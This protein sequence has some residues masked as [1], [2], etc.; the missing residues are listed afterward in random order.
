MALRRLRAQAST[1]HST[2]VRRRA[3]EFTCKD[4]HLEMRHPAELHRSGTQQTWAEA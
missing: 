4:R 3:W 2:Y 1:K